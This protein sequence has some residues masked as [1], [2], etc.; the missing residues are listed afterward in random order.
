MVALSMKMVSANPMSTQ[1]IEFGAGKVYGIAVGSVCWAIRLAVVDKN[2]AIGK[3]TLK[4]SKFGFF[5]SWFCLMPIAWTST[6]P[7][8]YIGTKSAIAMTVR[9][10]YTPVL[11]ALFVVTAVFSAVWAKICAVASQDRIAMVVWEMYFWFIFVGNIVSS[12]A[13]TIFNGFFI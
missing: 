11:S 13:G 10:R 12:L 7:K 5:R 3:R 1:S 6:C 8:M 9:S 4:Y 2:I